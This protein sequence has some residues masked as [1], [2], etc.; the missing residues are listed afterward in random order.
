MSST[1]IDSFRFFRGVML[2]LRVVVLSCLGS[3]SSL[4][5]DSFIIKMMALQSFEISGAGYPMMQC[6]IAEGLNSQYPSCDDHLV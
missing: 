1:A 5:L 2:W 6:S 3:S 4:C